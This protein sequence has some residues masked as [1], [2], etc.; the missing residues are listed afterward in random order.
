M[1]P[2]NYAVKL[3]RKPPLRLPIHPDAPRTQSW[4]SWATQS[5]KPR[6]IDLFSGC[7]GLSLGLE[8]AGYQVVLSVDNDPWAVESHRHNLPGSAV[9][10]DLSQ[11]GQI[12]SL[13]S[14]LRG[15][16]I[17]LV[18]GGPPCQPF[19]RAGRSKIR[20]LVQQGTRNRR[21]ERRE[22]WQSFVEVIE[23]V[24]PAAVLMENVPDMALGDDLAI[25]R[26]ITVRLEACG[27]DVE[28]RLADAWRHGVPQHR[29]RLILIATKD[30]RPFEW[31]R[32][33]KLVTLRD[34]ISDLPRLRKTTGQPEMPCLEPK[35]PFQRKARRGMNGHKVVWDHVSRAVRDDDREAFK[36]MKPGDRY[37]D[38]PEHLRRYRD[39]IFNDKYNKLDW[40]SLCRSITAH[41]AKDGYWYIHPSEHRTLSV[42]E[43]ARVQTFPD[44]F[45]FAGPRS[46]AFRQIG[47][48]VPPALGEAM[49]KALLCAAGE[50]PLAPS[51]R[52][53]QRLGELRKALLD[54]AELDKKNFRWRYPGDPWAVLVGIVLGDRS[55]A[56]NSVIELFL[57]RF[58]K[59]G[60]RIAGQIEKAAAQLSGPS[61]RKHRRLAKYARTIKPS[62]NE[63][64][65]AEW[66]DAVGLSTGK[67]V[68]FDVLGLGHDLVIPATPILR[69]VA[70]I[71]ATD[72]D[73]KNKL[74]SGRMTLGQMLGGAS[75]APLVAASLHSLG[76][77][78][79]TTDRPGCNTCPV[80]K[81]CASIAPVEREQGV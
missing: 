19:S 48:A 20:S 46:A 66:A 12:D 73:E 55:E 31:P 79:C 17:D 59:P 45:R 25:I 58:P 15:I 3:E 32:D 14:L 37:G 54:W 52:R 62:R 7:G 8:Q 77:S 49:G 29:Q 61:K 10:L 2:V 22:L 38:L 43:A 72:I 60:L 71:T 56:S 41:I 26:E 53:S 30:G 50:K 39:D 44:K 63:K 24:G 35:T 33:Q 81:Y 28:A 47:N 16:N 23:R 51:K 57:E 74:S 75:D 4:R 21:D 70:R 13:V 42:R 1:S 80:R 40:D 67:K 78:V 18:A 9:E 64:P 34:A 6:A 36:M 69:T 5:T 27:Y 68:L 11:S 65:A 76:Q